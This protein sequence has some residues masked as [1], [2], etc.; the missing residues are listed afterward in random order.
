MRKLLLGFAISIFTFTAC[1]D[2]EDNTYSVPANYSFENVDYSGQ[3]T[4]L[5][6]LAEMTALAKTGNNGDLVEANTLANMY[7]NVNAPFSDASLNSADKDLKSKTFELDQQMVESFFTQIEN[8]SQ[9]AGA[10]GSNGVAGL[11]TTNDGSSTYLFDENGYEPVQLIEKG[12]MGSCFY[13]QMLAVYL[14]EEKIGA[15]V[16]N[17]QVTAGKGTDMEH[18]WDEAFGYTAF[19]QDYPSN[20][21]SLSFWAKYINGRDE[22]LGSGEILMNAFIEGRAAISASD[23]DTKNEMADII[24]AEMERVSGATAIHYINAALNAYSDDAVRNHTLSEAWAF[25]NA[26]Q[27][28]PNKSISTEQINQ[29]IALLG[30]NFYET[31]RADLSAAKDLLA[32]ALGLTSVADQL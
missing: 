15:A 18:H 13:Y 31:P 4:R 5:A 6:M 7:A 14:S 27:Y 12:L 25:I 21:S 26:L 28:N 32:N 1:D 30:N 2:T 24:K 10:T 22:L 17:N 16:D 20:S 23:M 9:S 29:A 11:V 8:A 3:E 19:P